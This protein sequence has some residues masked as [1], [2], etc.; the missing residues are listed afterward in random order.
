LIKPDGARI[1]NDPVLPPN[2][3]FEFSPA[4]PVIAALGF[5]PVFG[6]GL[7]SDWLLG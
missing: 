2:P 6:D 7:Q 1:P 5:K 4:S 3:I